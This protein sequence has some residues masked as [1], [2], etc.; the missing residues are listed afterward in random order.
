MQQM[1][2]ERADLNNSRSNQEFQQDK[3]E[4]QKIDQE[5]EEK[6]D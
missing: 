1:E 5:K 4:K 6:K 2:R 3:E